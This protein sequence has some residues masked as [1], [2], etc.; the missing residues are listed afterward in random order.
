MK[1]LPYAAPP[2]EPQIPR[3]ARN[4]NP[5]EDVRPQTSDVSQTAETREPKSA[6]DRLVI[7]WIFAAAESWGNRKLLGEEAECAF[8]WQA[9]KHG[10]IV[11]KPYG[12]SA[13]Y[14]F[15]VQGRTNEN[16]RGHRG[17]GATAAGTKKSEAGMQRHNQTGRRL[18]RPPEKELWRVQV[19][20]TSRL[21]KWNRY[22]LNVHRSSSRA[23]EEG[24]FDFFAA[25]V[26]PED[27]WYIIP[28]EA[29]LPA[30]GVKLRPHQR[31]RG[32]LEKYREAWGLIG[33]RKKAA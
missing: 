9:M 20:S 1:A 17:R 32:R 30:K 4:D 6:F 5:Q 11:A 15:I 16:H 23:Y 33:G 13:P 29:V 27:V 24:E 14:D 19:K 3:Y 2:D 12:D 7:P 22:S 10:L 28:A 31:S 8:A 26:E 25:W 18:G 21:D